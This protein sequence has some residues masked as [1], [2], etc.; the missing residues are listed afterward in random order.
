MEKIIPVIICTYCG[1]PKPLGEF[2]NLKFGKHGKHAQCKECMKAQHREWAHNHRK[3]S[4]EYNKQRRKDYP[5]RYKELDHQNYLRNKENKNAGSRRWRE[6]NIELSSNRVKQWMANHPFKGLE[7]SEKRRA[8]KHGGK[9]T[10]EEW[11]VI[12]NKYGRKCLR[13]GRSD[14]EITMDHVIPL[15]K[16]GTHTADNIQPLCKSCNSSKYTQTID[17]RKSESK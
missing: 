12:L 3:E 1:I 7:Y 5:E 8:A 13:C 16:G 11:I 4:N 15:S 6:N 17:Y 14:V 2:Y 10:E 9:I